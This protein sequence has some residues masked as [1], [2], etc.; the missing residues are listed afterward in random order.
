MYTTPTS[1]QVEECWNDY[2]YWTGTYLITLDAEDVMPL[3]DE[4]Y[5]ELTDAYEA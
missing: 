2:L 5:A 1:T 3:I 4:S